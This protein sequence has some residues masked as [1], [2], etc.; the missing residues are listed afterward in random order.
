MNIYQNSKE[1]DLQTIYFTKKVKTKSVRQCVQFYYLWKKVL[2][3]DHKRLRAIRR[4]REQDYNLR[5][6]RQQQ[7]IDTQ[8]VGN[9]ENKQVEE[10]Q[11]GDDGDTRELTGD[12][13]SL[14][15]ASTFCGTFDDQNVRIKSIC[16][17]FWPT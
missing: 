12:E 5:S 4:R 7:G 15:E 3:D 14:S 11:T 16:F 6:T 8:D 10:G 1:V 17:I 2:V 13:D 9:D